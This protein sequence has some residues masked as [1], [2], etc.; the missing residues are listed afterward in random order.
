M[1]KSRKVFPGSEQLFLNL[2]TAESRAA[3]MTSVWFVCG[4]EGCKA[5]A[6]YGNLTHQKA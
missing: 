3:C 1:L 5:N 4:E 6:C 2:S